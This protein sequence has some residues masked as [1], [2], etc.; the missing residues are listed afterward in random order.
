MWEMILHPLDPAPRAIF[1]DLDDTLCDYA[2]ARA[3][4]LRIAFSMGEDSGHL[5]D[6][7]RDIEAMIAESI[8]IHPHGVDHFEELFKRHGIRNPEI[9][10]QAANWYRGNRFHGLRLF[11][12][13]KNVLRGVRVAADGRAPA[14]SRPIGIITNGPTEVQR[15]KIDLLGIGE[16]IDFVIVSEEFGVAKPSSDIFNAALCRAG[17]NASEAV[18][19]GDSV[20]FDMVGAVNM[21]M[22]SIWVNATGEDWNQASR[23]PDRQV[24][25]VAEVP[26][27]VGSTL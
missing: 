27:L 18:F 26:A 20:E 25:H 22:A 11:P 21:G 2:A 10:R 19:V 15:T 23:S 3:A 5:P 14:R 13:V 24:R 17:V 6:S 9:P 12:D 16:L 7:G 1:F 4:R 8:A